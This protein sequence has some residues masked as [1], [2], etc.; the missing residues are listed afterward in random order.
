MHT[1]DVGNEVFGLES[2]QDHGLFVGVDVGDIQ[3]ILCLARYMFLKR[4]PPFP[5]SRR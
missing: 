1:M 3:V 5:V 4:D 2:F